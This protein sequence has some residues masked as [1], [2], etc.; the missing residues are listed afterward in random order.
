MR[1]RGDDRGPD[2]DGRGVTVWG[3]T[4]QGSNFAPPS[5]GLTTSKT[6]M[7]TIEE[8]Q[9]HLARLGQISLD[10][11]AY[12]DDIETMAENEEGLRVL[13]TRIGRALQKICL[14]SHPDETEAVISG[15]T[16]DTLNVREN[17]TRDPAL[18]QGH[19]VKVASSAMYLG[20]RV[21]QTGYRETIH[22]TVKHRV[23][24]AWGRVK[25]IKE[26]INNHRMREGL[27]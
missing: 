15:R 5:I 20:M 19:P 16:K 13:S 25:E 10:P 24:K 11:N 17:L 8:D 7:E 4:G 1:I 26:V 14:Q 27:R 3:T 9:G 21:D 18:M 12:V 2:G 6:V 23:T 22:A